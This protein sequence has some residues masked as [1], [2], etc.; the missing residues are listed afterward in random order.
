MISCRTSGEEKASGGEEEECRLSNLKSDDKK[1]DV[2][3]LEQAAS[4]A[5]KQE[6]EVIKAYCYH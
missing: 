6:Q 5:P 4:P 1:L 3:I 2:N